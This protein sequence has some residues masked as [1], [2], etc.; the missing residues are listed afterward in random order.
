M[1]SRL[2]SVVLA[3]LVL[4]IASFGIGVTGAS[5]QDN[6]GSG[7]D[8]P[9]TPVAAPAPVVVTNSGVESTGHIVTADDGFSSLA[10][11]NTS[12]PTA[13]QATAITPKQGEAPALA[14]TGAETTY[15]AYAGLGLIAAGAIALFIRKETDP[16]ELEG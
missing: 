15:I 3:A 14:Y 11:G 1:K 13:G 4:T 16:F 8:N 9:P 12:G 6:Y 7:G 5:A 2:L 10:N